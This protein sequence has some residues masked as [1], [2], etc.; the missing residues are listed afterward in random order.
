MYELPLTFS[1]VNYF[2]GLQFWEQAP[3]TIH[4]HDHVAFANDSTDINA[5]Q[6]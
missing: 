5:L 3:Q 2:S 6:L 1:L 4:H